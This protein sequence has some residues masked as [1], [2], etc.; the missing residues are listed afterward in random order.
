MIFAAMASLA[1]RRI[2]PDFL[3][4]CDEL[5]R[6]G[7]LEGVG[8]ERYLAELLGVVPTSL[9]VVYYAGIVARLAHLRRLIRAGTAIADLGYQDTEDLEATLASADTLLGKV[10][11]TGKAASWAPVGESVLAYLASISALE[12]TETS[13]AA[14]STG[15]ADLD[16]LLGGLYGGDLVIL[17][18]RPGFGKTSL[19]LGMASHIAL[20]LGGNVGL[21]SLEMSHL[22]VAG[23]LLAGMADI[24]VARLRE[25]RV[26][27]A[28]L[29][30][31]SEAQ[32]KLMTAPLWVD[33]TSN[34]ALRE[35]EIRA[36]RLHAEHP[37]S[38]LTV[39]YLQLVHAPGDNRVQSI[40][41][42]SRSLK[43]LAG[44]L[45]CP[46]LALS[47][48]SRAVEHRSPHTPLLSDLRESGDLEQDAD[49]VMFIYREDQYDRDTELK[50]VAEII[51][52]KQRNGPTGIINLLFLDRNARFVSLGVS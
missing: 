2:P 20:K 6:T 40:G 23:R 17:A 3:M 34:L 22:Q 15:Y 16:R 24:D 19:A 46:V 37:L 28:E 51:V 52:A 45:Q 30:R 21:F 8:G 14:A 47:Q 44:E 49:V 27:A 4:L 12:G 9:H 32:S 10:T 43:G 31:I 11:R 25:G 29:A 35:L 7:E 5:T 41:A 26:G 1:D 36:R 50:G 13:R 38:L 39:D 48:L 18:A 33:G 42:I